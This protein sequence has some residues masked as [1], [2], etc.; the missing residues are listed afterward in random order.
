MH[1]DQIIRAATGFALWLLLAPSIF[2]QTQNVSPSDLGYPLGVGDLVRI[3]VYQQ[4]DM[5]TETRVSERGTISVPLLGPVPVAGMT[6]LQVEDRI[7][8]LLTGKGQVRDPQVIVTVMKFN[9]R[10]ASV[11]GL[12][13]TP[14]R[15]PL[16]EGVY[17]LTDVLS[18]AGGALPDGAET[19]TIVRTV[20]GKT[21]KLEIDLPSL[22]KT[23]DF[24]NNP[25]IMSGDSIYVARAPVF[26]IYGEVQKPG[27]Y[28]L[29]KDM[30]LMQA[31]S[32]GGGLTLR[33]T[34]D[35]VQIRRRKGDGDYHT[36]RGGLKDRMQADDVIFVRESVF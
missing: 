4:P 14:G 27:A 26:Y 35:K 31:I 20:N 30:T 15:Y 32:V 3:T 29:E 8:S 9:S 24:T 23:G 16:E 11:L 13:R 2:A 7:A 21:Q 6:A 33:G 17:R 10:Q 22:F 25:V 12:V 36:F 34:D 1:R 5:A 18:L 19:V 28:R